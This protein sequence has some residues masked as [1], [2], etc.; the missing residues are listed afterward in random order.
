MKAVEIAEKYLSDSKLIEELTNDIVKFKFGSIWTIS[1]EHKEE[2]KELYKLAYKKIN[3]PKVVENLG[4]QLAEIAIYSW[5][6]G[7][8]HNQ[9]NNVA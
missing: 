3:L 8:K 1:N 4:E 5:V 9:G 6:E 2:N 7:Y